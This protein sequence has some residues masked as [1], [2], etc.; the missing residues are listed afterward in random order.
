MQES[1]RYGPESRARLLQLLGFRSYFPR[2]SATYGN[3][4]LALERGNLYF[5][6]QKRAIAGLPSPLVICEPAE[7][8]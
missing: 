8:L 2:D 6:H 1:A 4:D 7:L 3:Y 5:E